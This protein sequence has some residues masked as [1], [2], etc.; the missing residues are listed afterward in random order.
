MSSRA[1]KVSGLSSLRIR[2]SQSGI[3]GNFDIHG[4]FDIPVQVFLLI[5]YVVFFENHILKIN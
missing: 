2:F 5:S 4:I 3:S 1:E